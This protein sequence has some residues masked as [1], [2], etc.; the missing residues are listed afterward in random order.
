MLELYNEG[1]KKYNVASGLLSVWDYLNAEDQS[2]DPYGYCS[3]QEALNLY[4]AHFENHVQDDTFRDILL[5]QNGLPVTIFHHEPLNKRYVIMTPLNFSLDSFLSE[6]LNSREQS[7]GWHE[8]LPLN[9]NTVHTLLGAMDTE[10]DRAVARTIL[11]IGRSRDEIFSLGVDADK[12]IKSLQKILNAALE[13]QNAVMA[14]EDMLNLRLNEKCEKLQVEIEKAEID[15]EKKRDI[16][17]ARRRKD[18]ENH[19]DILKQRVMS[20]KDLKSRQCKK[21]VQKHRQA[22]KRIAESLLDENRVK[23]RKL[24][25]GAKRKLD[26]SDEDDIA[27]L[28]QEKTTAHG[29]RHDTILYTG[30]SIRKKH[31]LGIANYVRATKGK[32]TIKSSTTVYNRGRPRNLRSRQAAKHIGKSLWCFK[33]PPKTARKDNELTHHQRAMRKNWLRDMG[34]HSEH[35]LYLAEDDKAYLRPGTGIGMDKSRKRVNLQLTDPDKMKE[36]PEHDFGD[37]RLFVTP[38]SHRVMHK[39]TET[40]D[41]HTVVK[42]VNDQTFA[43]FR[44][45]QKT[46]SSASVWSSEQMEITHQE[47]QC[48]E[49]NNSP[50]AASKPVRRYC[51]ILMDK[52]RHFI[53][54]TTESDLKCVTSVKDCEFRTYESERLENLQDFLSTANQI[55]DEG[56]NELEKSKVLDISEALKTANEKIQEIKQIFTMENIT[57]EAILEL[58]DELCNRLT[59][60]SEGAKMVVGTKLKSDIL[61]MTDKGPG[62]SIGNKDVKFRIAERVRVQGLDRFGRMHMARDDNGKNEA[63]RSNA[64]IGN[65]VCDGGALEWDF[66]KLFDGDE[67][68]LAQCSPAELKNEEDQVMYKNALKICEDLVYRVDDAPGPAGDFMK[69]YVTPAKQFFWDKQY[70]NRFID[71]PVA[72]RETC[73]GHGWYEKLEHFIDTHIEIGDMHLEF[74]KGSCGN[75]EQCD[76]CKSN[77]WIGPLLERSPKPFPDHSKLPDYTYL[78]HN[79]TQL[80]REIDDMQP[81]VQLRKL[82]KTQPSAEQILEFCD[83]YI[84]KE[85]YAREFLKHLDHLALTQEKRSKE[86]AELKKEK[87]KKDYS[88]YDWNELAE[89]NELRKLLVVELDKYLKHNNLTEYLGERKDQKVKAIRSHL[90]KL[91]FES[92]MGPGD[93]TQSDESNDEDEGEENTS[94]DEY[95]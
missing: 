24:G 12:A 27:N 61:E 92:I 21:T 25:A 36:L 53:D 41:D 72:N 60:V 47:P 34:T 19:C 62:V 63:E 18:L 90:G 93:A 86:K 3:Y 28:I 94:D 52:S 5:G 39:R 58:Y 48:F 31:L 50:D 95:E 84:V 81:R 69:A 45:K 43:F 91:E 11:A 68:K 79:E 77:P 89:R 76:W 88:E 32:S 80:N 6:I 70:L 49:V 44:P 22:V 4:S 23:R 10:F 64:A 85:E 26:D 83:K 13:S 54:A 30:H 17:S 87:L 51:R 42:T 14:A 73:P 78:P 37:P 35:S 59:S 1:S 65:A 71:C 15:L 57:Q 29:R 38:S 9:S 33:A 75:P 16:L 2:G 8:R 46:G 55:H 82:H 7:T 67:N 56:M 66:F 20:V 74:L 40:I